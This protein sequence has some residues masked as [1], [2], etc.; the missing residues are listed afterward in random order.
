MDPRIPL[1]VWPPEADKGKFMVLEPEPAL[2]V[3]CKEERDVLLVLLPR[4]GANGALLEV[5]RLR[6]GADTEK[7][8]VTGN[9]PA[10]PWDEG[11]TPAVPLKRVDV[12]IESK[13]LGPGLPPTFIP[14]PRIPLTIGPFIPVPPGPIGNEDPPPVRH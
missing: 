9:P 8:S 14:P 4:T 1:D 12:G 5:L 7:G 10:A 2:G 11:M 3:P 6:P 13:G